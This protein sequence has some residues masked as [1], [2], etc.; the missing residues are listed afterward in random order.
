MSVRCGGVFSQVHLEVM[1]SIRVPGKN[2][3]T[4]DCKPAS[5]LVSPHSISIINHHHYYCQI[6]P[7]LR[8]LVPVAKQCHHEGVQRATSPVYYACE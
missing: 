1:G 3:W 4:L 7:T 2:P 5:N 6:R 8:P